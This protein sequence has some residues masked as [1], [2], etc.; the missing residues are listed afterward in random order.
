VV[1]RGR[2]LLVALVPVFVAVVVALWI[3]RRLAHQQRLAR[4]SGVMEEA[5]IKDDKRIEALRRV[6]A[7]EIVP[8]PDLGP[9]PVDAMESA[10]RIS[11]ANEAPRGALMTELARAIADDVEPMAVDD[12]AY[13]IDVV[14]GRGRSMLYDF[15]TDRVLC[16]GSFAA[17]TETED[18]RGTLVAAGPPP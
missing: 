11:V 9:C 4:L 15:A 12:W 16:A 17:L 10:R 1:T 18:P 5:M 13:E 3:E 2:K 14:T 8:R 6:L 7:G